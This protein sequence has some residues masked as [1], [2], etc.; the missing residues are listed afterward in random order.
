MGA[1]AAVE[2]YGTQASPIA[3]FNY[4]S[5]ANGSLV[6]QGVSSYNNLASLGSLTLTVT[7]RDGDTAL[8]NF[9]FGDLS[10]GLNGFDTGIKLSTPNTVGATGFPDNNILQLDVSGTPQNAAAILNSIKAANGIAKLTIFDNDALDP[11]NP[12][13]GANAGDVIAFPGGGNLP[14]AT[15]QLREGLVQDTGNLVQVSGPESGAE[16]AQVAAV[17][18]V[19]LPLAAYIAPLGAGLAGIYSRRFRRQK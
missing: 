4:A 18:A 10:I 15:L 6:N 12:A 17:T 19:P 2:A 5:N 1:S 16:F 7:I 14:D 13:V 3:T 9:D 8:G 11:V